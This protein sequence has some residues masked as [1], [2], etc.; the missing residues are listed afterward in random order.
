MSKDTGSGYTRRTPVSADQLQAWKQA[1]SKHNAQQR[2]RRR[3]GLAT[4]TRAGMVRVKPTPDKGS[5]YFIN[6]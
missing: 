3:P 6:L 2:G 1:L 4:V 5:G